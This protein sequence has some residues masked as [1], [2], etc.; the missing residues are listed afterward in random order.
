MSLRAS[1]SNRLSSASPPPSTDPAWPSGFL[2]K[3]GSDLPGIDA[4]AMC[5]Q[6]RVGKGLLHACSSGRSSHVFGLLAPQAVAVPM[7]Y[8]AN[9]NF[10][11]T[12]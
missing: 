12:T 1:R 10:G 5:G 8:L 7:P 3:L 2:Q 6:P 11:T 4:M 9:S